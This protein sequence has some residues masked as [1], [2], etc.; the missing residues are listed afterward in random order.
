MNFD[1]FKKDVK[2]QYA[3]IRCF[4]VIGEAS[5][6]IPDDYKDKYPSIPWRVMA[7]MRDRYDEKSGPQGYCQAG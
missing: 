2:T 3:I 6:R 5:K 4:E 1:D 7:G